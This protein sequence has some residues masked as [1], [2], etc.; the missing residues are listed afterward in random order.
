ML[1]AALGALCASYEFDLPAFIQDQQ[2]FQEQLTDSRWTANP[3]PY[4]DGLSS[5]VLQHPYTVLCDPED[6]TIFVT[7]FTLN[8]VVRLRMTGRTAAQYKVV[9]LPCL[10]PQGSRAEPKDALSALRES[11]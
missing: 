5:A 4:V 1:S 10:T 11:P 7:S 6:D 3:M 8:H 2:R 9:V